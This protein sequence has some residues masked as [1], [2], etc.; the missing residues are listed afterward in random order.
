[1]IPEIRAQSTPRVDLPN[2]KGAEYR[3]WGF[4]HD[5]IVEALARS[6]RDVSPGRAVTLV[7]HDW[8]AYWGYWLHHRHPELVLRIVGLDVAPDMKPTAHEILMI[9]GYQWW[10]LAAFVLGGRVGDWMTRRF[11]RTATAPRQGDVLNSSINYPYLYTWRDIL[12][13][14]ASKALKGYSPQIPVMF[15]YGQ[16]KPGRFHSDAWLEFVRSRPGNRVVA[17]EGTGHWVTRDPRLSGLVRSWL[18]GTP[19]LTPALPGVPL[20]PAA[21]T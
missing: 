5:E 13:G 19:G 16:A 4:S 10:L 7:A 21:A 1:M 2:Y 6:V 15:I 9:I 3:R 18:D 14:R 11:A 20:R 12:T 17:L 8:G